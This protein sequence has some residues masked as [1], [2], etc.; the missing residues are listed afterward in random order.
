VIDLTNW[1]LRGDGD[2][3]FSVGSSIAGGATMVLVRFDPSDV[4]NATRLAAFRNEYGLDAT[5]TLVGPMDPS[6]GNS[7]GLVKLQKPDMAPVDEPTVVPRVL[8][9]EVYYDDL[10]PWPEEADAAGMS[11]QRIGT[12]A[13]GN[14]VGSWRGATPTPGALRF[15]P[16]IQSIAI[17]G[18]DSSRSVIT[19]VDIQFSTEV[20]D[21]TA[22]LS[23]FNTTTNEQV[24]GLLVQSQDTDRKTFVTL[25]FGPGTS[26]IGRTVGA[27][28]LAGGDYELHVVASQITSNS[29]ALPM[30]QDVLWGDDPADQF[31]RTYGDH[32]GSG[33]VD[34][35]DFAAFRQTFG[36]ADGSPGYLD[37]LDSNGDG[38][39]NLFDFATFRANFG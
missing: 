15:V 27:N 17:N 32:D 33:V 21:P 8:V 7:Y 29:G 9:D 20:T 26:V 1:R 12:D 39:I 24:S 13:L 3:D 4:A 35:F 31:F 37:D 6:L 14:D 30:E 28:T 22:A 38:A 25:T 34:L 10:L 18:G 19:S 16:S 11:L 23:L 36:L 5:V 2:F